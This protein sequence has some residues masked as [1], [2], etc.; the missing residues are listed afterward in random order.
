MIPASNKEENCPLTSLRKQSRPEGAPSASRLDGEGKNIAKH[1]W[2]SRPE[3]KNVGCQVRL[4][5]PEE[6]SHEV[7]KAKQTDEPTNIPQS[8]MDEAASKGRESWHSEGTKQPNPT[9]HA[10]E[11]RRARRACAERRRYHLKKAQKRNDLTCSKE[12]TMTGALSQISGRRAA[13][14][15]ISLFCVCR[16][17]Q[18]SPPEP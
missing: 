10:S 6:I 3:N 2:I 11:R 5:G 14:T 18:I 1:G 16:P 4:L 12:L 7:V 17:P 15:F 8:K 13:T 9:G